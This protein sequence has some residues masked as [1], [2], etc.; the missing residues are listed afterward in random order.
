MH[1]NDQ[2]QTNASNY[3]VLLHFEAKDI[4][5]EQSYINFRRKNIIGK[6]YSILV[7]KLKEF[8]NTDQ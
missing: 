5:A 1:E 2:N 3:F 8:K 7:C 4:T 6:I